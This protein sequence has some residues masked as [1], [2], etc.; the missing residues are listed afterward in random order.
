MGMAAA[1]P[2]VIEALV[3]LLRDDDLFVRTDAAIALGQLGEAAARPEVLSALVRVLYRDDASIVTG[4]A[5]RALGRMGRHAA[6]PE[7]LNT[8]AWMACQG[9]YRFDRDE[10]IWALWRIGGWAATDSVFQALAR[11]IERGNDE[12]PNAVRALWEIAVQAGGEF[13]EKVRAF[14]EGIMGDIELRIACAVLAGEHPEYEVRLRKV[15]CEVLEGDGS[16]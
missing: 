12:S 4:N 9:R 1:R 5:A 8:L 2:E 13:F 15:I 14:L 3:R 11:V 16:L 10:A 7:V 6:T